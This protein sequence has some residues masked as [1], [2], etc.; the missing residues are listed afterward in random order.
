MWN[1]LT[2]FIVFVLQV[3]GGRVD[4]LS[5]ATYQSAYPYLSKEAAYVN[6]MSAVWAESSEIK[7]ELLL[8]LAWVESRYTPEATSRVKGAIRS[9]GVP[10]WKYPPSDVHGPYFCGVTQVQAGTSWGKCL[11]LRSPVVAYVTAVNELTV[12]LRACRRVKADDY[13][14]C[15]LLG[16]GGG[17]PLIQQGTST[18]PARV[19]ARTYV[20]KKM[21]RKGLM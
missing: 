9:T 1:T 13:T 12:W 2:H 20:I 16:H 8:G 18:Y 17:W 11:Q 10:Q 7:A 6:S 3:F 14:Q 21:L 19:L 5:T 15:M 4:R